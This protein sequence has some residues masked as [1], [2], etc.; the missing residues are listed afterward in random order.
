V[1]SSVV[2]VVAEPVEQGLQLG[3]GGWLLRSGGE[4]SF[5]GL[6]EALDFGS[7]LVHR[8]SSTVK[9]TDRDRIVAEAINP[10]KVAPAESPGEL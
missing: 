3:E 7:R 10:G 9:L 2:V 1:R 5:E 8:P 6:L 4:P